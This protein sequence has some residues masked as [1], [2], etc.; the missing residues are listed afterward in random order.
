MSLYEKHN[1][2]NKSIRL[3]IN[4]KLTEY[5]I[6][7]A[8]FNIIKRDKLLDYKMIRKLELMNKQD[9]NIYIGKLQIKNKDL[10]KNLMNGFIKCR[11]E[12]IEINKIN[13]KD[14]LYIK[15]DSF[16][17]IN[18]PFLFK[19]KLDKYIEFR[20][21][22]EYIAYININD[23]EH[24]YNNKELIVKGYEKNIV[25]EQKDYW[26]DFIKNVL[27]LLIK[28]KREYL[29]KN[30]IEFRKLYLNKKLDVK[31]YKELNNDYTYRLLD[32]DLGINEIDKSLINNIDI[33]YN[34]LM[35]FVPL[36]TI[37]YDSKYLI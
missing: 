7:D 23:N 36:I 30:L 3:I 2:L 22:N 20:K 37:L 28:N 29:I 21:K 27:I 32:I 33:E 19:I 17:L 24:Y 10:T 11:R 14:I 12:F 8:G 13:N 25:I 26:F 9:R 35:Y 15:K 31:F 18:K 16:L 5:D 34:Y 4:E 1:Y 6:K